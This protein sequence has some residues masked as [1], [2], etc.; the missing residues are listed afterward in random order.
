MHDPPARGVQNGKVVR[1]IAS[2]EYANP[3][4]EFAEVVIS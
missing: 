1:E 4:R 3:P 2:S